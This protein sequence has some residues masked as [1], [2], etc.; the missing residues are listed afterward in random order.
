[1]GHCRSVLVRAASAPG[2]L[3][4]LMT[5]MIKLSQH[6]KPEAMNEAVT[7]SRW[8]AVPQS[9]AWAI[10]PSWECEIFTPLHDHACA[11]RPISF[12]T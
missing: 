7:E 8:A 1:M 11:C 9:L 12:C 2:N 10:P 4:L 6:P 3:S 5:L